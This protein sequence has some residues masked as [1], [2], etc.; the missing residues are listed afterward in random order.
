[1]T[2]LELWDKVRAKT[3]NTK[4][5]N[6]D[7][8]I[9][10]CLMQASSNKSMPVSSNSSKNAT[11]KETPKQ[12]TIC[13]AEKAALLKVHD[14]VKEELADYVALI[15]NSADIFSQSSV[16]KNGLKHSQMEP[17]TLASKLV[18]NL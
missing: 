18:T 6:A 4:I 8:K 7:E 12:A 15:K 17:F 13:K 1:M 2:M 3:L 11:E 10:T 14:E 16:E 5:E 9:T